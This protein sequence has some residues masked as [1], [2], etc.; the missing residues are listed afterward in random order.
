MIVVNAS[1]ADISFPSHVYVANVIDKIK[2]L[3]N[4]KRKIFRISYMS[5]LLFS[6]SYSSLFVFSLCQ[7]NFSNAFILMNLIMFKIS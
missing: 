3:A 5:F 6:F 1:V 4:Q 7:K 2:G